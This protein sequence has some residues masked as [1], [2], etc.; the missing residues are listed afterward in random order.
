MSDTQ[1]DIDTSK[2]TPANQNPWYILMTLYGEQEG[3][4]ID[5][6]LHE[7]NRQ[8]WNAWACFRLDKEEQRIASIFIKEDSQEIYS[9]ATMSEEYTNLFEKEWVKRNNSRKIPSILGLNKFFKLNNT[10]FEKNLCLDKCIFPKP[11]DTT[12]SVFRKNVCFN[13]CIFLKESNFDSSVFHNEVNS[14]S[15]RFYGFACFDRSIFKEKV[16]FTYSKFLR[17]ALF[18]EV[19]FHNI[20]GFD[21]MSFEGPVSFIKSKFLDVADFIDTQFHDKSRFTSALFAS[22]YKTSAHFDSCNF[23][24]L[25]DFRDVEFKFSYPQFDNTTFFDKGSF[26]AS[27]RLWPKS[28]TGSA[29]KAR[30]SCATIRHL[31][32]QQGLPEEAHFFFRRELRFAGQIGGFWQ[33]LPYKFYGWLSEYGYSIKRP[34]LALLLLWLIGSI[35]LALGLA[36]LTSATTFTASITPASIVA[37]ALSFSNLFPFFGFTGTYF[38]PGFLRELPASLKVLSAAQTV[39]SLPLLFFLGL[40]LRTRFRMR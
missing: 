12:F 29:A 15:A 37:A 19:I 11:I 36:D 1:F 13:N 4:E 9:W 28:G 30:D 32:A 2:L 38:E 31:L 7:K 39:L 3:D 6:D 34:T 14:Y 5:W 40:G 16:N 23:K 33:R 25:V 18:S 20:S 26:T 27:E 22:N 8:A 17:S 21:Y 10:I 24:S 35:G